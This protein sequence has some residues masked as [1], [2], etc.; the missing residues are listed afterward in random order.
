MKVLPLKGRWG[1]TAACAI[2]TAVFLSTPALYADRFELLGTRE[3]PI[4]GEAVDLAVSAD[5]SWTFVLTAHGEVTVY[6]NA[7]RLIQTL[8]T[9]SGYERLE[10]DEGGNR[11]IL[12]GSGQKL[13]V[14]SLA[15]RFEID[16]EASPYRGPNGA[17]VIITIYSEFQCPYCARLV[18]L[19]GQVMEKYP[20]KVALQFKNFPL[21]NHRMARPA[22]M[23]AMAADNQGLFWEYHDKIFEN[24]RNLGNDLFVKIAREV[25]LDLERFE[26][27]RKSVETNN[28]IN[29]DIQEASRIGVRGTP[30]VFINGKRLG[31][32]SLEAF[33]AA[34][35]KE[36]ETIRKP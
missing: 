18:P 2:L 5:G 4:T 35:E 13:K 28:I 26:K 34:I 15:M 21:R 20:G 33:S 3:I 32:R 22:A 36:L 24:Y 7:G 10:Y 16:S 11:L 8:K 17:P 25:N 23:A 12:A 29:R 27:D 9:G 19:L 6:D 1:K 31:Q 30:T 14:I